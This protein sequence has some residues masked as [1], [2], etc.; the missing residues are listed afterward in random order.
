MKFNPQSQVFISQ[1]KKTLEELKPKIYSKELLQIDQKET[2][3]EA[4][5][6]ETADYLKY[7]LGL[8]KGVAAEL[9]LP[10]GDVVAA[11][12]AASI[13]AW[14]AQGAAA[15]N[16]A[17]FKNI[18]ILMES[19]RL[20]KTIDQQKIMQE[21]QN[22]LLNLQ[23]AISAKS[24]RSDMD[25]LM[26]KA[27]LF[28]EQKISPFSFYSYLKDLSL[29][30]LKEGMS[31]YPNLNDF[32]DYLTKVN[33]LDSTK[34]FIEMEALTYDIKQRLAKKDEEK[35]LTQCLRNIKFLE[36]FFNLK[37]S[38]EELDYYLENKES[39]KVGWFKSA[40]TNLTN[41][42]NSTNQTSYI[43]FNPDL[44][45][46]HLSELEDFYKIVKQR[47]IAMVNNSASEIEKRNIKVS[48]LISGGFHTKGIT[49]LLKEKGYS[50]IV[51]SP[52]SKTDMDEENYHFLLSGRRKP[53]EELLQQLAQVP[54][55]KNKPC[56][57]STS[58]RI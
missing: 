7:L 40:I 24:L 48:A 17:R 30:H 11:S 52:Y 47:D 23:S 5:R 26:V 36:G 13:G 28:K 50:Y 31:K 57:F 33:S 21:S 6:L 2:D 29:K 45:D 10:N 41:K 46:N 49:K 32:I 4:Q 38:N 39:H 16:T 25:S 9:A 42:T 14:A 12:Y 22:L 56:L 53:I 51:V 54:Q 34:L 58:Y 55:L 44:I 43:D 37:I 8:D 19:L 20:E 27:Q 35:T 15:A 3:Y 18:G 1:A